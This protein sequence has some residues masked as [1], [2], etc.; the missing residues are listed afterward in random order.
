M[1]SESSPNRRATVWKPHPDDEADVNDAMA[2]AERGELLSPEAS[3]SFVRW[4]EGSDD[5]SWHD[6]S[7]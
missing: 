4:L 3:E 5:E 7:E 2:C 1:A 6:E